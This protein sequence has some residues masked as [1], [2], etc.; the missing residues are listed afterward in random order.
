MIGPL[1]AERELLSNQR[2]RIGE[3][4]PDLTGRD[5]A[6]RRAIDEAMWGLSTMVTRSPS[7]ALRDL[8]T[9]SAL[10]GVGL[11]GLAVPVLEP[12]S[13][14]DEGG[15]DACALG[16]LLRSHCYFGLGFTTALFPEPAELTAI[17]V[18][19]IGSLE[20]LEEALGGPP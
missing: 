8:L 19:R 9:R 16:L 1:S 17:Q 4:R 14:N 10:L 5:P 11:A 13:T 15:V 20:V 7:P 6:M 3:A 2:G 12:Y 18:D